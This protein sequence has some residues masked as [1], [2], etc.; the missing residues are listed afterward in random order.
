MFVAQFL[1]VSLGNIANKF[2]FV[3]GR[4]VIQ[5]LVL[6][7]GV[8]P[9]QCSNIMLCRYSRLSP[10]AVSLEE[11]EMIVLTRMTEESNDICKCAL[12]A[13]LVPDDGDKICVQWNGASI[14]PLL[15]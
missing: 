3:R 7:A 8:M 13:S 11:C 10:K 5:V 2:N 12:S 4:V 1:E 9:N 15:C 6:T 14:Q